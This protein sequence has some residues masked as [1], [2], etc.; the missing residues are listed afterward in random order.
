MGSASVPRV[1]AMDRR[2][3]LMGATRL[4]RH[5]PKKSAL[6]DISNVTMGSN[7]SK[8][9]INAMDGGAVLI[10]IPTIAGAMMEATTT[11]T[12]VGQTVRRWRTGGPAVMGSASKPYINAMQADQGAGTG[13]ALMGA[14]RALRHVELTARRNLTGGAALMGIASMPVSNAMEANQNAKMGAMRPL[15]HVAPT[16]RR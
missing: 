6:R 12:H 9:V 8:P 10:A 13:T 3:A 15:R 1:Y 16:A 11:Q 7:A 2:N 14:M 4:L 5:V